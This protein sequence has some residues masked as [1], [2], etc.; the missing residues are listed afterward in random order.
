MATISDAQV[1]TLVRDT[2]S[3]LRGLLVED[4]RMDRTTG[5]QVWLFPDG[6]VFSWNE[7]DRLTFGRDHNGCVPLCLHW[8]R[9]PIT[10]LTPDDESLM[11]FPLSES[12]LTDSDEEM[13]D[14]SIRDWAVAGNY[15]PNA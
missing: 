2:L 10:A 11:S 13:L 7:S 12:V 15:A 1:N 9:Y 3:T 14:S 6:E 8:D 5:Y 4:A